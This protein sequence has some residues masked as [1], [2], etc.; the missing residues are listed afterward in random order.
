MTRTLDRPRA[1]LILI[2][3]GVSLLSPS[4]RAQAAPAA[5]APAAAAS[6]AARAETP[7]PLDLNTATRAELLALPGIGEAEAQRIIANRPY[8][9]KADLVTK[10]VIPTGPYLMLKERVMVIPKLPPK[11]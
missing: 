2:T 6:A 9:T 4:M 10:Q 1:A 5:A 8:L 11:R 3:L 7:R